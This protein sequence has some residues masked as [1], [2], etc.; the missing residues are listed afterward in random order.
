MEWRWT[1]SCIATSDMPRTREDGTVAVARL[2][3]NIA[4]AAVAPGV[5][6]VRNAFAAL[7]QR[8]LS[9]RAATEYSHSAQARTSVGLLC[10]A[11]CAL[12]AV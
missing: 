11:T 8:A 6:R 9:L 4:A 2:A 12:T 1:R 7:L 10:L 3:N 5:S